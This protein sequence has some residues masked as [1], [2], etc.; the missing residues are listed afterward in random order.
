MITA[1][2]SLD[3]LTIGF[4]LFGILTTYFLIVR[5]I[6]RSNHFLEHYY[7]REEGILRV[8][9]GFRTR[10][11]ATLLMIC[12]GLVSAYDFLIPIATGIDWHGLTDAVPSWAWPIVMFAMAGLF[13]YLR[14]ITTGDAPAMAPLLGKVEPEGHD[15]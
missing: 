11:I 7:V 14:K 9:K 13:A 15:V 2:A 8:L 6:L 12:S 4:V 1:H 3:W 5:P 10:I